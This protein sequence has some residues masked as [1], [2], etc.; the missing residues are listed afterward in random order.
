MPK[1]IG[2]LGHLTL[3]IV[4]LSFFLYNQTTKGLVRTSVWPWFGRRLCNRLTARP[5][6]L[7]SFSSRSMHLLSSARDFMRHFHFFSTNRAWNNTIVS[8]TFWL[9][10][11]QANKT[12]LLSRLLE[13]RRRPSFTWQRWCLRKFFFCE[14]LQRAKDSSLI[15]SLKITNGLWVKSIANLHFSY[16]WLRLA[17]PKEKKPRGHEVLRPSLCLSMAHAKVDNMYYWRWTGVR[18]DEERMKQPSDHSTIYVFLWSDA[19]SVK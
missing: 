5:L 1:P 13:A 6:C 17:K 8:L 12:L 18:D 19:Y 4:K 10:H 7:A 3:F 14:T 16:N 9:Y 15:G 2:L 11:R